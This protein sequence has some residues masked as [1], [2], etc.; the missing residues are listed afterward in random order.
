MAAVWVRAR[1]ELRRRWRATLL[2]M[3]VTGLAGGAVL[4][5]VAGARRTDSAMDR[6]LAYVRPMSVSVVGPDFDDVRRLPQVADADQ[7]AYMVLVPST[8]SGAPDPG[9]LGS[10]NP[11]ATVHGRLFATLE[12]PLL[13]RGRR[14]DP[15]RPLE[16][17]ID[18]TLA[19]RWRLGPGQRLRL[20]S[21]TQRQFQQSPDPARV[22]DPAGPAFD[23]TVVGV[24]RHPTDLSPV[25]I[26]QDVVYLGANDLYLTPAFWRAHGDTVANLGVGMGV[27]L[28]RGVAD[29]HAFTAAVR[30]LPGGRQAEVEVGSDTRRAVD[31][32]RRAMRVQA[33]ALLV[34]AVL[35]AI[36]GLLVVGQGIAR[37]V[38]LD[39]ADQSVLR[40]VGMTRAQLVAVTLVRGTLVGAGGALL[41]AILAVA[42]SPLT[43]IGLARQAEI[44]PGLSVDVPVLALGAVA[45]LVAVLARAAMAAWWV[46]R[47]WAGPDRTAQR[48]SMVVDRVARAGAM[49]SAIIGIRL[50]L[51]P[52]RGET[53]TPVRTAM[54]GVV[55]AVAAVAASLAFAASL[56]RLVRS[57]SLQ[58]WNWD[59]I[60][61]DRNGEDDIT[62]KGELLARNPLVSGYSLVAPAVPGLEVGGTAVAAIAVRP[63]KGDV[64]PRVLSG[65]EPR[66]ADEIT[67]G[68]ATL[69]RLGR[70]L[71][72]VVAAEGAGGR[73]SFRIVGEVLLPGASIDMTMST[74]AV[75]TVDG[76]R[77]VLP[78]GRPNQFLVEYA[79]GADQRAAYASLRRD[80][81]PT[82]LRAATPEEVEN[83][84]RVSGLPFLLA[85]LLAVLGAAT[86]AH[87]LVTSVR[88]RRR[89]L[90]VLKVLGFVRRQV[91][92]TVVWQATSLA[93]VALLVGLPVGVA[94]GRWAWVLVNHGLGSPA[95]PVT[96][97]LTVLAVVPAT[98]LLANLVG[99]LPARAAAATRPAVVLRSE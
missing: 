96:P 30:A 93:V 28:R 63:V 18:E 6:F 57:P 10:I 54:V 95:G 72:D 17:A 3:A 55:A 86:L 87:L 4:A 2:L 78:D 70:R 53:A 58:G 50:A 51:E 98:V 94:A 91:L 46:T 38:Q 31:R 7:G 62:S 16:V 40:A 85:A 88:R 61:G 47:R 67:L 35:T 45:V 43:P 27:R 52:G 80:F 34:F 19:A 25:P 8:P 69:R 68:R 73:R 59:V 65:R 75:L 79:P 23:F 56:D 48:S 37:Q 42:A 33:V 76:L 20:W 83:L 14:P 22:P 66:S 82:V 74:G 81:G 41:A 1:A 49:P 12:R 39:A 92:S 21:Y 97:A 13:V 29:L 71:G 15:T 84:R 32:G 77:T 26:Q 44:D 5:A 36:A 64:L 89:D 99:A 24:V 90:A 9:A 60:V 11:W